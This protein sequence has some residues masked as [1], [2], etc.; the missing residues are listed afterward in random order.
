MKKVAGEQ[1]LALQQH[2]PYTS[3]KFKL[4]HKLNLYFHWPH[5]WPFWYFR[6]AIS[7]FVILEVI[8]I[9]VDGRP[10]R[11][12]KIAFLNSSCT[13]SDFWKRYLYLV[14]SWN[15]G[16]KITDL[17]GCSQVSSAAAV[18][19][20]VIFSAQYIILLCLW[21]FALCWTDLSRNNSVNDVSFRAKKPFGGNTRKM[22]GGAPQHLYILSSNKAIQFALW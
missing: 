7:I 20:N 3:R 12:N 17:A 18:V 9:S 13:S 21:L 14:G 15:R 16:S 11:R 19:W 22:C 1:K 2:F 6:C 4:W 5:T 10:N 8:A